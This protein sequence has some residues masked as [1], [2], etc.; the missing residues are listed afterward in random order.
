MKVNASL[1]ADLVSVP[2]RIR[3]IEALGYDGAFSA[4][5]NSDPFF[6]LL[7]AAEHSERVDSRPPSLSRSRAVR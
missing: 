5:I 1:I 3:A 7:L 4:E 2:S 6:P